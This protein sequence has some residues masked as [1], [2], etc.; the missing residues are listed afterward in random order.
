[1]EE[2]GVCNAGEDGML[3][4]YPP[5]PAGGVAVLPE[6]GPRWPLRRTTDGDYVITDPQ[7]GHTR[8]FARVGASWRRGLP[9]R[10]VSDR[11]GQ[12]VD[13]DYDAG[14]AL[15]GIRHS[16]GYRIGVD[17]AG[18]R[19]T[20][21]RLLDAADTHHNADT[22]G[23]GSSGG[24]GGADVLVRYG[25]DEGG[26]LAEVV[27]SSGVPLRFDYDGAGRLAGWCDRNGVVYRYAY[28]EAGHCVGTEGP[29]GYMDGS[30]AYDVQDRVTTFT[31][32]LGQARAFHL[33]ERGQVVR[34]VD[35]LGQVSVS[36]WDRYDRLLSRTDPLGRS[37]RYAYDGAGNLVAVTRADGSQARAE[38]NELGLPVTL[39]G[40]DGAVRAGRLVSVS[41]ISASRPVTSP[42]SGSSRC[43]S[44]AS[45][46]A[47]PV[48]S[49]RVSPGPAV[50]A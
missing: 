50:A 37:T 39:T 6:R 7:R 41:S 29:G 28:D 15:T 30:F 21:L 23:S 19:V 49:G 22:S 47:S 3:L 16:G 10:A 32:S 40:P 46:M 38:Y 9:L 44:R 18:G 25:Y 36:A 27:N 2:S 31:D 8:Y 11:N 1:V 5:A 43:I 33:N 20:A 42:S 4:V 13:F 14:G 35:P 48:R 34:E 45:R 12:R 26:R 24:G 17:S